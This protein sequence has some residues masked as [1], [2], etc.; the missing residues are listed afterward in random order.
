M[1]SLLTT[2][3]LLFLIVKLSGQSDFETLNQQTYD[4]Y[5]KGDY[6]NLKKTSDIMISNGM[7]YYYLRMRL[8]IL[9][10]NLQKYPEAIEQFNKALE[11]NSSDTISREYIYFSYLYA[12][13]NAD[14]NLYLKSLNDENKNYNLLSIKKSGLSEIFAATSAMSHDVTDYIPSG[15]SN[16]YYEAVKRDIVISAGFTN[17]IGSRLKSTFIYTNY[18]KSGTVYSS[19]ALLG[20]NLDFSQNQLYARLSDYAFKG[21][22][23]SAFGHL[24]F[25]KGETSVQ[26]QQGMRRF[27]SETVIEYLGGVGISKNLW[28]IRS[29]ANV[30]TSNFSKSNQLRGEA[31]L[32]Y[33]PLGNLNL[34][35][36]LGGM[37]QTDKNWGQTYQANLDFG[38]KVFNFVWFE[39][40]VLNG[41]SFLNA[42]NQGSM[43]NNSFQIPATTFH[44]DLVFLIGEKFKIS[45][46]ALYLQ[47]QIY[48]WDLS[49]FTRQ[50]KQLLNSF[51]GALKL[52]FMNN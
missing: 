47:N 5:L 6:E 23:F 50:D 30:S 24:A 18:Q 35:F 4:Y 36:T 43:M 2:T 21:W 11:F 41:N 33:L 12:G 9:Q 20:K 3:V 27:N 34:Y 38:I 19:S 15:S 52:T 8:G 39:L 46:S 45:L 40:G 1:R 16:L 29:G 28:K 7:D 37:Y 44:G 32:S 13:L 49:T 48:T 14:A 10:Y 22:E 31:Y 42:R 25:Y 51:G 26:Q 17:Y